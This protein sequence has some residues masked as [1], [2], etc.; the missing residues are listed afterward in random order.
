MFLC[1]WQILSL[2]PAWL[3][4]P[5]SLC[6]SFIQG[7]RTELGRRGRPQQWH[8]MSLLVPSFRDRDTPP[9]LKDVSWPWQGVGKSLPS[10][11]PLQ[12]YWTVPFPCCRR[13]IFPPVQSVWSGHVGSER[14]HPQPGCPGTH[15]PN[16]SWC[17]SLLES[18]APSGRLPASARRSAFTPQFG[19]QLACCLC[20][21]SPLLAGV[22]VPREHPLSSS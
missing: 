13:S 22:W 14:K 11:P 18:C 15:H 16:P 19:Q 9:C 6:R 20:P 4:T 17:T 8:I 5:Y 3:T 10:H 7:T 21:R 12:H 1:N 2:V